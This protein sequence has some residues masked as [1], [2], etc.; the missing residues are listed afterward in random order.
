[1]QHDLTFLVAW[2]TFTAGTFI[3]LDRPLV[4]PAL[5]SMTKSSKSGIS[6]ETEGEK[7]GKVC[8]GEGK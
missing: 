2:P 5:A 3:V 1:L 8:E 4:L 7:G 6:G